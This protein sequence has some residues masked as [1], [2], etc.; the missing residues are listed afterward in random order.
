MFTTSF[1]SPAVAPFDGSQQP[2]LRC[3]LAEGTQTTDTGMLAGEGWT[4]S[5]LTFGC[6]PWPRRGVAQ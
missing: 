1:G 5:R 2:F 6:R 3:A 4:A